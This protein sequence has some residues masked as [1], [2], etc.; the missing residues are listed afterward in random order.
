[1]PTVKE[2][3]Y[4]DLTASSWQGLFVPAGTPKE[5]IDKLYDAA[6]KTMVVPE[7]VSRLATGGAFAVTSP[8]PGAFGE[9]VAAET[10]RWARI[11][12]E[13]NATAD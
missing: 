8:N 7:V 1:V 9:Y 5:A 2:E 12:K 11:A 3:G 4:P 6:V 13:S 10:K